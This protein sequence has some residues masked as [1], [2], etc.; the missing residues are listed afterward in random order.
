MRK[1]SS[2][3]WINFHNYYKYS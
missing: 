1:L 3:Y 2:R